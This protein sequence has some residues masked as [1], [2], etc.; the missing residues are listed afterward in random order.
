MRRST[1]IAA[2]SIPAA[3]ALAAAL[4]AFFPSARLAHVL[5]KRLCTARGISCTVETAHLSLLPWPRIV[6]T[7]V[8]VARGDKPGL[9]SAG[10]VTTDL[11]FWPLMTGRLA[12]SGLS[13][14]NAEIAVDTKAFHGSEGMA[15]VLIEGLSTQEQRWMHL[16]VAHV[17]VSNSRLMDLRGREWASEADIKIDLPGDKGGLALN[18]AARWRG[19]TVRVTARVAQPRDL[20]SGGRSDILAGMTTPLLSVSLE[21][22]A[23]GGPLMQI[24]GTFTATSANPAALATWLDENNTLLPQT[25]FSTSGNAR[26]ARGLAAL[27]MNKFTIGKT[28]LE[29]NVAFRR[30]SKGLQLTGTLAADKLDLPLPTGPSGR[31]MVS[32]GESEFLPFL[33]GQ[34]VAADVRLSAASVSVGQVALTNV[35]LALI[36]RDRKIDVVLAGADFAN[37]RIKARLG[38]ALGD[39]RADAKLQAHFEAVDL[40]KA[41]APLGA[42]RMNGTLTAQMLLE[43]RGNNV[44]EFMRELDGKAT[45]TVKQ[46]DLVGINVPEI[47]RRIEKRP[48]LTALDIRGGR[49][50][51]ETASA[52]IRISNGVAELHEASIVSPATHIDLAGTLQLPERVLA[53][54]GLAAPNRAEGAALPFEIKGSF[55]EPSLIPDA[56]ALIR[57]SGAAAPFFAPTKGPQVD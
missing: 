18:G 6:A 23:T 24:N 10:R 50:P 13:L 44:A 45:L 21:G 48:L 27:T 5:E 56:R 33:R 38:F 49:T 51:F 17:R 39:T 53:L 32:E 28:E 20:A 47:L 55:D 52:T 36:A 19:E 43:T 7:N 40:V 41:L 3:L 14:E 26:F 12:F 54:K 2:F 46:G 16:P 15:I 8:T 11:A 37:G 34:P 1:L 4:P 57:R 29:G 25:A 30:D 35:G 22:I 31:A 9:A 42:K